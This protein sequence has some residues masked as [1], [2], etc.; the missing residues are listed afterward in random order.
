[1][2]PTT[3][4]TMLTSVEEK[5]QWNIT[6]GAA[7]DKLSLGSSAKGQPSGQT[8]TVSLEELKLRLLVH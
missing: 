4:S 2:C 7:R 3:P 1:M 5:Q 8:K 6:W